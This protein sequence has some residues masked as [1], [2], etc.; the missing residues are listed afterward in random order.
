MIPSDTICA[1]ATPPGVS[2]LAVV[3]LSGKDA[4]LIADTCFKGK[5]PLTTALSHTIHY[6]K[7]HDN[8]IVLDTVTSSVFRSPHSYTGEDTVEFG[9]HGGLVVSSEL[10]STLLRNGARYAEP[11]EFTRRAF[12]NG[13]LDLTQ[14]EAVADLIHASS[15]KGSHV[16]ARQLIGG[17]TAIISK[18]RSELLSVCALLELELDFSGEDVE[19]VDKNHL[20][21]LIDH[22]LSTCNQLTDTTASSI[23]RDGFHVG[24]AGFPNAGKS[25]FFNSLLNKKRSIVSPVAGTTRDY[26]QDSITLNGITI[27]VY[28]TAGL[29]NDSTDS[30]EIEGIALTHSLL[31]SSNLIFVINDLTHGETHSDTLYQSLRSTYPSIPICLIHNKLDQVSQHPI[32]TNIADVFAISALDGQGIFEVKAYIERLASQSTERVTDILLN[33]RHSALLTRIISHLNIARTSLQQGMSNEF[34]SLDIRHAISTLGEI[35]GEV[36][37]EEILNTIFSQFCIGK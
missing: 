28:D 15:S 3:R 16:A 10:I 34:I 27:T 21:H 12:L 35:T 32:S 37:N 24:L 7:F 5:S 22:T 18:L 25:T 11:G 1:L 8:N 33:H 36:L 26:I 4:F 2:G 19:F 17:F 6:G 31:A 20:L 29:R 9:C 23:L 30:I 14:V 13:K